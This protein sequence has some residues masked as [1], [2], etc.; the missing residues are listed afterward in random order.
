MEKEIITKWK[1]MVSSFF[2]LSMGKVPII[3]CDVFRR[4]L[5][6]EHFDLLERGNSGNSTAQVIGQLDIAIDDI[7]RDKVS[8]SRTLASIVQKQSIT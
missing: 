8:A 7:Y 4:K 3:E 1:S 2:S 5:C 6:S